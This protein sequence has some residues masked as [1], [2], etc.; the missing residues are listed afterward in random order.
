MRLAT[1]AT[2]R[3]RRGHGR[4]GR[5]QDD[6]RQIAG[7]APSLEIR[8]RRRPSPGCQHREDAR[9]HPLSDDD[10]R[11]WLRVLADWIDATRR[12]GSH[13]V[14]ACSALKQCHRAV[15]IGDRTDVRLVYL[16]GDR[17]LI[18]RRQAARRGHFM[19]PDL[20]DSQFQ[21][22]QEPGPDEDPIVVSIAPPP[23]AIVEQI[24]TRLEAQERRA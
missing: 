19:P 2:G 16:K 21:A 4:F 7:R 10:R 6:H 22:L 3:C 12:A 8:G 15:I 5:R 17:A 24:R 14:V 13:G 18:R 23:P 11:P 1:A 9:R 20:L